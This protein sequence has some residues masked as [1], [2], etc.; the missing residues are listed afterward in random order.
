MVQVLQRI[1][2]E[3]EYVKIEKSESL[4]PHLQRL[5]PFIHSSVIDGVKFQLIR[6]GGRLL[7]ASILYDGKF[8]L[9]LNSRPIA[10][11]GNDPND[12]E[13]LTPGHLLIGQALLS[14]PHESVTGITSSKAGCGYLRR[15]R[16]LSAI[17]QQFWDSWSKD[18]LVSLQQRN[19][20]STG[21]SDVEVGRLVLVHE[22]NSPPQR[23]LTGRVVATTTGRDGKVRVAQIQTSGGVIKRAIHK[24]ALLPIKSLSFARLHSA[25]LNSRTHS[26]HSEAISDAARV[27]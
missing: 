8:P 4:S 1:E 16:M 9:L 12:E 22:D 27:K 19:K 6:V 20:W 15:W 14:L 26:F 17:K 21:C 2:F 3:A 13:A 10:S 24:L 5:N 18:Y 11:P 7:N 23:W 25:Y